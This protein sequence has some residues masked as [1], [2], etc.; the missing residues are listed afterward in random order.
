MSVPSEMSTERLAALPHLEEI[1]EVLETYQELL[2]EMVANM[3]Q[4][5][6]DQLVLY[7]WLR[8]NK[9]NPIVAATEL[10]K[11]LLWRQQNGANEV[12]D[13]INEIKGDITKF[14]HAEAVAQCFPKVQHGVDKQGILIIILIPLTLPL[15]S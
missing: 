1:K 11:T 12:F 14:P 10:D 6:N 9:F 3:A 13:Y 7:R 8:G 4:P 2:S 15:I 5:C